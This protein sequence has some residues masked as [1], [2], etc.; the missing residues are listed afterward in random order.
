LVSGHRED[1]EMKEVAG[2]LNGALDAITSTANNANEVV[3]GLKQGRGTAGMLLR[4]EATATK[5]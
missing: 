3:L 5:V 4:D 1:F 2:R